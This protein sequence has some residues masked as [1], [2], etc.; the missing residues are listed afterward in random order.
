MVNFGKLITNYLQGKDQTLTVTGISMQPPGTHGDIDWLNKAVK[1]LRI[2]TTLPG[3]TLDVSFMCSRNVLI[4]LTLS[5][6]I[7]SLSLNHLGIK[8]TDSGE[9]YAPSAFS[10]DISIVYR[11]PFGFPFQVIECGQHTAL[12]NDDGVFAEVSL[13]CMPSLQ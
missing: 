6:I 12:R 2:Q 8:V 3:Q 10:E 13:R 5:Q 4:L 11:N 1:T 7:E 9:A